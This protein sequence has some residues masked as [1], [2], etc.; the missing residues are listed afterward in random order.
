MKVK[1]YNDL[2]A[3]IAFLQYHPLV[4]EDLLEYAIVIAL[5]HRKDTYFDALNP[6]EVNLGVGTC[7]NCR[8]L[9]K[10]KKMAIFNKKNT[11]GQDYTLGLNRQVRNNFVLVFAIIRKSL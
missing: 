6:I 7:L 9:Q 4:N 1:K 11:T 8:P 2:L 3:T 10:Q 5:A